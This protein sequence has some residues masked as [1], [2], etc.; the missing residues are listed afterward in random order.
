MHNVATAITVLQ[1]AIGPEARLSDRLI[2]DIVR[3]VSAV[4]AP[5]LHVVV[6]PAET[7]TRH[8]AIR[9]LVR[10]DDRPPRSASSADTSAALAWIDFVDGQPQSVITVSPDRARATVNRAMV[11]G[12]L[13]WELPVVVGERLTAVAIG[14]AIAHKVG[15]YLLQSPAH[16]RTGLMRAGLA[17]RDLTERDTARLQLSSDQRARIAQRLAAPTWANAAEP[18]AQLLW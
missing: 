8:G 17:P 7:P 12:R 9:L 15:H 5:L 13:V 4:W 14:R 1:L 16:S 3:A 2:S 10:T 18:E 6:D 11:A